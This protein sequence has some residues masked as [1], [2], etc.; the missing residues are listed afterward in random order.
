MQSFT[1]QKI[2]LR[3]SVL[4]AILITL[5]KLQSGKSQVRR[6]SDSA[7]SARSTTRHW[8]TTLYQS[9]RRPTTERYLG[10]QPRLRCAVNGRLGI[11]PDAA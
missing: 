6:S 2:L 8:A 7:P 11:E 1:L 3:V 9:R 10:W 4:A 5:L